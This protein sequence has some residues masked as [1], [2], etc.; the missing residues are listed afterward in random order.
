[1]KFAIGF[2][3]PRAALFCGPTSGP[4]LSTLSFI[5]PLH[6]TYL[7]S[8]FS[9]SLPCV[10][11]CLCFRNQSWINPVITSHNYKDPSFRVRFRNQAT[12]VESFLLA[13]QP[14][15]AYFCLVALRHN[16]SP[17]Q[18]KA[19]YFSAF[20]AA[21]FYRQ[22]FPVCRP[23]CNWWKPS[24]LSSLLGPLGSR[25]RINTGASCWVGC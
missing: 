9:S 16:F 3:V 19:G 11:P 8:F 12:Q 24:L 2:F 5:P 7:R 13:S 20:S 10:L 17:S 22:C 4:F 1:M 21:Q 25:E 14:S 18:D 15:C 6:S 23:I